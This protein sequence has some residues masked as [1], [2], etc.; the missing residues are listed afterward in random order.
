MVGRWDRARPE[1]TT[2]RSTSTATVPKRTATMRD[3]PPS[4]RAPEM[5]TRVPSAMADVV[6]L[7]LTNKNPNPF[8]QVFQDRSVYEDAM[9]MVEGFL[10]S[11]DAMQKDASKLEVERLTAQW[12]LRV[13]LTRGLVYSNAMNEYERGYTLIERYGPATSTSEWK[14]YPNQ[15]DSPEIWPL[16]YGGPGREFGIQA[17]EATRDRN[18]DKARDLIKKW[19]KAPVPDGIHAQ[20]IRKARAKALER[21]THSLNTVE[22]TGQDLEAAGQGE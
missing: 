8:A 12:R 11:D 9:R 17:R 18:F 10:A 22:Q 15:G 4:S 19:S 7:L 16:L 2:A 14:G 3:P 6:R 13:N 20:D 21:L 1:A 5:V